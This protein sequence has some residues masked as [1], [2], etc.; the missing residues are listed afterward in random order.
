VVPNGSKQAY[1]T[2]EKWQRYADYIIEQK[3]YVEEE[4]V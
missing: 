4:N 2:H 3:D 1:I